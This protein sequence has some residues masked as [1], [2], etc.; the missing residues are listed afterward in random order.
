MPI[1]PT[2]SGAAREYIA[3]LRNAANAYICDQDDYG[4]DGT[5]RA[6]MAT[7]RFIEEASL[8]LPR[9]DQ[10]EMERLKEPFLVLA[11]ALNDLK[12]GAVNP[13]IRPAEVHNR[14]VLPSS[15]RIGRANAAV[16]LELL[17]MAGMSRNEA[18]KHVASKLKG[19]VLFEGVKRAD[20]EAVVSWRNDIRAS[21]Y[22]IALDDW[23][24]HPHARHDVVV[25]D[26]YVGEARALFDRGEWDA[27][28]LKMF[29][30][31][32]VIDGGWSHGEKKAGLI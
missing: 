9:S 15:V 23:K 17:I 24:H 32:I 30:D 4:R 18:A 27:N 1:A 12:T 6:L 11:S 5:I 25:F 29:A 7:V 20:W 2:L 3:A 14:R 16:A 13:L 10:V 8:R 19:S 21:D 26:H 28:G 31:S 22:R